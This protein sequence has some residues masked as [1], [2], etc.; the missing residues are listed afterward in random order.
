MKVSG[1]LETAL[2]QFNRFG[3]PNITTA[4]IADE[5]EISP[6]NLY[7][8][9]GNKDEIVAELFAAFER[10]LDGLLIAPARRE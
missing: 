2:Q 6:G 1:I 9:F 7:Y 10:R 4:D 8:H 3:E 5:M